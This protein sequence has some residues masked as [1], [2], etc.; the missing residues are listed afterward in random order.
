MTKLVK[1]IAYSVD[2]DFYQ[3]ERTF[4]ETIE[5]YTKEVRKI[6]V[7]A[8]PIKMNF[9]PDDF[10]NMMQKVAVGEQDIVEEHDAQRWLNDNTVT[11]H[12]K[13][14][15][16]NMKLKQ[17]CTM[18]VMQNSNLSSNFGCIN[19]MQ[20]IASVIICSI[21]PA[22]K[23]E[24]IERETEAT[25][26]MILLIIIHFTRIGIDIFRNWEVRKYGQLSPNG[27]L[28]A[29]IEQKLSLAE[30][31]AACLII[32]FCFS[33]LI[34]IDRKTLDHQPILLMWIIVDCFIMALSFPFDQLLHHISIDGQI[35]KN[36]YTIRFN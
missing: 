35:T 12:S 1:K 26:M 16:D 15:L 4:E 2:Y 18:D 8:V 27:Q 31:Y 29:K 20:A 10:K 7:C 9:K 30:L 23:R 24:F 14:A 19:E 6:D 33:K 32:G 11:D 5:Y 3:R 17:I 28:E 25:N 13:E 22:G 21:Y 36:I 34:M